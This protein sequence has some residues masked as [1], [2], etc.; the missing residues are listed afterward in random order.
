MHLTRD[1]CLQ[2]LLNNDADIEAVQ[3]KGRTPLHLA[4][5]HASMVP[6][7]LWRYE[8]IA[9]IIFLQ[10]VSRRSKALRMHL[11]VLLEN[12]A[13][14]DA[15]SNDGESPLRFASQSGHLPVVQVRR[16]STVCP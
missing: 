9:L 2:I 12:G 6:L 13:D 14:I 15:I 8:G 4:C 1:E 5:I 16:E 10:G 7:K 3:N 11:Q